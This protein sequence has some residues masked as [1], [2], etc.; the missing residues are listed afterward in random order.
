MLDHL[1]LTILT[2]ACFSECIFYNFL[3]P[4]FT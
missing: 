1:V 3:L 4:Y 2:T